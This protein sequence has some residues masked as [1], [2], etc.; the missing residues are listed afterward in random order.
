MGKNPIAINGFG[1]IGRLVL[2]EI[3][4]RGQQDVV[5]INDIT[6]AKTLAYLFKYDSVHRTFNGTVEYGED[7]ISVDGKKIKITAFKN[8]AELPLKEVGASFVIESTGIFTG[9]EKCQ[10][11]LDAGAQ[12]VLITAPAK[13]EVDA[14]VVIGCNEAILTPEMKIVSNASCTTNSIAPVVKVIHEAFGV[15]KGLLTTVHAYTNDQRILDLPHKDLRR[16]RAAALNTIPT[17]TGAA[18]AIGIVIPLLKG[19]LD[20]IS[21]R[22]PVCDGS[23]T[24]MTLVLNKPTTKEEVNKVVKEACMGYLKGIIDYNE[25]LIVSSDVIGTRCSGLFDATLTSVLDGNLLKIC[26]WYDNEYGYSCRVI[27]LVDLMMKGM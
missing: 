19:K 3:I 10:A 13:G 14:T 22:V 11:H 12:K 23:I 7:Y 8:P 20:G 5:L 18:K 26:S 16:A 24:D 15:Q 6:D 27:D 9:K 21:L 25:D 1:R 2:R 17:T 4:R